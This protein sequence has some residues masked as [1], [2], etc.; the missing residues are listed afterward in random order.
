[1]KKADSFAEQKRLIEEKKREVLAKFQNQTA[2]NSEQVRP[3]FSQKPVTDVQSS[4]VLT[5]TNVASAAPQTNLLVN[6]GNFLARFQEMQK[7]MKN[8]NEVL[9]PNGSTLGPTPGPDPGP[10]SG[11]AS[12]KTNN[13]CSSSQMGKITMKLSGVKKTEPLL[14]TVTSRPSVFEEPELEPDS[15]Q[16]LL[17]ID[18]CIEYYTAENHCSQD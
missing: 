16:G 8:S 18:Y 12:S 6:D 9:R 13:S 4:T 11:L 15:T 17:F 10:G 1:M 2:R 5:T 3:H 14:Q 7:Q